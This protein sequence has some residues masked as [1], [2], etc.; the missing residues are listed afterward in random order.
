MLLTSNFKLK[1]PEG[2]D[3][4][5]V[6]DFNENADIIDEELK[7]R[8]TATGDASQ[9]VSAFAQSS[10]RTNLVSGE[11]L[12]TSLG[13]V[14]KWFADLKDGAFSSV[15][16]DDTTTSAGHVADARIVKV[17]GEE[18]DALNKI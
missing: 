18:I 15:A 17:H 14:K 3:P 10:T 9:M 1:K 12:K 11:A 2:I 16:N 4:V 7:K 13:K 6:K 8:P 5:D